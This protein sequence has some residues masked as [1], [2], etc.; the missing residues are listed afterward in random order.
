MTLLPM[1]SL[2]QYSTA[3]AVDVPAIADYGVTDHDIQG[4][5]FVGVLADGLADAYATRSNIKHAAVLEDRIVHACAR[6]SDPQE[7]YLEFFNRDLQL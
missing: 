5:P 6:D 2:D 3:C 4:L 1:A 7:C